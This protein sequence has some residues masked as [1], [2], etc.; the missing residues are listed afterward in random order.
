VLVEDVEGV[1][2]RAGRVDDDEEG[3]LGGHGFGVGGR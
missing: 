3:F 1:G 2:A